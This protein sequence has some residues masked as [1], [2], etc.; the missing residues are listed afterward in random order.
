MCT[1]S[2]AIRKNFYAGKK[3]EYRQNYLPFDYYDFWHTAK[4][5]ENLRCRNKLRDYLHTPFDWDED[6]GFYLEAQTS[7]ADVVN[8]ATQTTARPN[9]RDHLENVH[10]HFANQTEE[11]KKQESQ[12]N[13]QIV[14]NTKPKAKKTRK[15]KKSHH[16]KS[17]VSP[18][19]VQI[20]SV[21]SNLNDGQNFVSRPRRVRS[22]SARESTKAAHL[23]KKQNM[24]IEN[25]RSKAVNK[26]VSSIAIQTP[27]G[28]NLRDFDSKKEKKSRPSSAASKSS[29]NISHM[30]F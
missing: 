28:W 13:D 26:S 25:S 23:A 30:N 2:A 1:V 4:E 15:N 24:N 7:T 17:K 5:N 29:G 14:D 9:R 11:N 6:Q 3:S 20:Q 19:N 8:H 27:H 10:K 22:M 21:D 12:S 18:K 16:S